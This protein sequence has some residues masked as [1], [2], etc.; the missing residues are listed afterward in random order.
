MPRKGKGKGRKPRGKR[1][2]FWLLLKL[3][4]VFVVLI[5][6]YGVGY[7]AVD[8]ASCRARGI[9]VTNTPDV[10]NG[11]C[12]DLAVGM[13]L[14]L[15]RGIEPNTSIICSR[16]SCSTKLR[17]RTWMPSST[18]TCCRRGATA[19]KRCWSPCSTACRC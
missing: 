13:M 5:A 19:L 16:E 14:A 18:E 15:A 11:D 7:D 6:I 3:F 1:G 9:S 12:A 17:W 2:W 10:L 8:L 4:I